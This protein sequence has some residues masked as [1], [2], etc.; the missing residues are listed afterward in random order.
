MNRMADNMGNDDVLSRIEGVLANIQRES[1][2]ALTRFREQILGLADALEETHR[3]TEHRHR[4]LD[5]RLQVIQ[6]DNADVTRRLEA[7]EK[8]AVVDAGH[9]PA[10]NID[11]APVV[12]RVDES[13]GV[14]RQYVDQSLADVVAQLTELK[15]AAPA[16]PAPLTAALAQPG[17][18]PTPPA[19]PGVTVTMSKLED[20]E[21][22]LIDRMIAAEERIND[23]QGTKLAQ[24]EA[25]L[26]RISSGFDDALV[27]MSTRLTNLD[28]AVQEHLE[29]RSALLP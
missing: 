2:A 16:A 8:T 5:V 6:A 3:I 26:G 21:N 23:L 24:F 15:A 27:A 19:P 11:F 1:T 12:R 17:L 22:R 14:L 7:L 20:L 9:A 28:N 29:R 25:T 10:P 13:L 18:P 4:E